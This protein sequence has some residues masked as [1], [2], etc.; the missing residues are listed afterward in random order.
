MSKLLTSIHYVRGDATDPKGDGVKIIAHICNDIGAW[1]KGFVLALSRRWEDPEASYRAWHAEGGDANLDLGA[2]QFVQVEPSLWVAN[3]VGQRG[4][5]RNAA[6]PPIRYQA[7]EKCLQQLAVKAI[8]LDASVHMPRIGC[9]LA[10]GEWSQIE[11]L[12]NEH[13][14]ER[15]VAVAVYDLA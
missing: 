9:G 10:G 15:G 11:S 3:M 13:L 2:V 12:V 1:G 4:I 14:C 5:K 8:E 7:V 6:G